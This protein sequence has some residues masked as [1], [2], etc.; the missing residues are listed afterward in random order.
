MKPFAL[1]CTI[2]WYATC[3]F[4][5]ATILAQAT[6]TAP[7]P[8]LQ[9]DTDDRPDI[10]D[11]DTPDRLERVFRTSDD[12][13]ATPRR[14]RAEQPL[15]ST[16]LDAQRVGCICMDGSTQ[17]QIGTGACAGHKGVRF[18]VHQRPNK[19]TL[20]EAT[21]RHRAHP[22]PLTPDPPIQFG[23][24]A[25]TETPPLSSSERVLYLLVALSAGGTMI[26]FGVKVWR[27]RQEET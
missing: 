6:V 8:T 26:V 12:K 27:Q 22:D 17:R 11:T 7:A 24:G 16:L 15:R 14:R 20:L 13:A 5:S 18:W 21:E 3:C 23:Q 2:V 9:D 1:V 10:Y 25:Q 4:T 19:D